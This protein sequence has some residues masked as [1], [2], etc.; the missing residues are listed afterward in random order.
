LRSYAGSAD[1]DGTLSSV[2]VGLAPVL[3]LPPVHLGVVR[4]GSGDIAFTWVR[5]SR[6]DTDSWAGDDAPLDFA[7]E[8]YRLTIFSGG[9]PVR[10]MD[11]ATPAATYSAGQ[12][13]TDFGSPPSSFIYSVAQ[14][15]AVYGP[16]HAATATFTA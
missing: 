4:G 8:G 6:A 10:T 15:S 16:G 5:R 13:T 7:P 14:L 3:P 9:T 12:Q 1:A 11:V 2:N